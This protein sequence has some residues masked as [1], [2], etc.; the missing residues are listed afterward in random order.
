MLQI[1]HRADNNCNSTLNRIMS[2]LFAVEYINPN[3]RMKMFLTYP[4]DPVTVFDRILNWDRGTALNKKSHWF[5]YMS[6]IGIF[7]IPCFMHG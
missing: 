2:V 6:Y 5:Y 3:V 1:F 7:I 4:I